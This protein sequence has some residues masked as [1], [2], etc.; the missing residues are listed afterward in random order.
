MH[1]PGKAR[2]LLY[3]NHIAHPGI[4]HAGIPM[5]PFTDKLMRILLVDM[6]VQ[7]ELRLEPVQQP[8][9]HT[10]SSVRTIL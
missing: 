6:A 10:K 2:V 3:L 5:L 1:P 9:K 8:H 4:D 7:H